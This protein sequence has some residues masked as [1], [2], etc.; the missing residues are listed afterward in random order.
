VISNTTAS[1]AG[2]IRVIQPISGHPHGHM[3]I[4]TGSGW[5]SDFKQTDQW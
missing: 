5:V 4:Y 3:Q 1:A 2:D